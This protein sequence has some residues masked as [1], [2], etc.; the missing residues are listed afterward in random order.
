MKAF[1]G[2]DPGMSGAAVVIDGDGEC[3]DLVRFKE[4]DHDICEFFR[5]R[6]PEITFG[7]LERVNA[8]PKQGVSSTFK[9]G[10]SYGFCGGLMAGFQIPHELVSPAVWQ[11]AMG[12]RSG[13]NKNI[14]KQAAQRLFPRMKITH[15]TADAFLLAE[16]A[17]RTFNERAGK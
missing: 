17:R 9:F 11:A 8:M 7:V 1:I 14:T 5:A 10:R 15:A 12:C 3:I 6:S 2:V 13:G 4:T 16:F